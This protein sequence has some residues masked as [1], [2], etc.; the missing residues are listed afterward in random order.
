MDKTKTGAAERHKGRSQSERRDEARLKL[1]QAGTRIVAERGGR[2]LPT[3]RS[4]R[5]LEHFKR[6]R[7]QLPSGESFARPI[8]YDGPVY[9]SVKQLI[10]DFLDRAARD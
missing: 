3:F 4:R 6:P 7:S 1:L 10:F 2:N 5:R 9:A 8:A